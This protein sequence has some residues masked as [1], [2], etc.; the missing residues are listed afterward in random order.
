MTGLGKSGVVAHRMAVS[1]ASTGTPAHF[2]HASEWVHG[3]L[4]VCCPGDV[5]VAIS[6]SGRTAECTQAATH[7]FARGVPLLSIVGK[8]GSPM[9]NSSIATI[10]YSI[11]GGLEPVGGAP[12]ASVVVQEMVVNAVVSE[13]ISQRRFSEG[14]FKFN[15]PGGSLGQLLKT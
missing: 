11:P 10:Q 4:G 2:V 5:V 8:P 9:E 7:F 15:H 13:L 3:D 12:T 1:L 14:D 6:H